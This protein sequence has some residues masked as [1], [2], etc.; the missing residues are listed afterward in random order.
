MKFCS[1]AVSLVGLATASPLADSS[2]AGRD[3]TAASDFQDERVQLVDCLERFCQLAHGPAVHGGWATLQVSWIKSRAELDQALKECKRGCVRGVV[4][5]VKKKLSWK[6]KGIDL[7][8]EK[9]EDARPGLSRRRMAIEAPIRLERLD[10]A[11]SQ[12][13]VRCGG[14]SLEHLAMG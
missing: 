3:M 8:P 10:R 13:T 7:W 1:Y 14:R 6:V 11:Q 12:R 2:L 5:N 4:R 9:Q